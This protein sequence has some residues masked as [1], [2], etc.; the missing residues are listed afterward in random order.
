[1]ALLSLKFAHLSLMNR[2]MAQQPQTQYSP[3]LVLNRLPAN[4]PGELRAWSGADQILCDYVQNNFANSL[5]LSIWNDDFGAIS[6]ILN[7]YAQDWYS[8]SWLAHQA[9]ELNRSQNSLPKQKAN[10]LTC[11]VTPA[12]VWLIKI[13]KS[14]ALFEYQLSQ[15]AAVAKPDQPIIFTGMV[16]FIAKGFFKLIESYL[17]DL[18]TSLAQK[19]AR[20]IFTQKQQPNREA[21][22][23]LK[24]RATPYPWQLCD[25]AGV[26]CLGKLDIGSRFMLEHLPEGNYQQIVDLG[27]GNGLLTL[28]AL[29]RWPNA[30]YH[31]CDESLMA[32]ASAQTNIAQNY[33][34]QASQVNFRA[35]HCLSQHPDNSADL[36]LCNPPFHQQQ[37]I[38]TYIAETMFADA[39]RSLRGNG[40]LC[41]VAN[42]H[43]PYRN[44]LKKRFNDVKVL[45][46]NS[47]FVIL[48][49][50]K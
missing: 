41:V 46:S 13:P 5:K 30:T 22:Y 37:V 12:D 50:K 23:P 4:H 6:C 27:C 2:P 26:F 7:D 40:E 49:A 34:K 11:E 33:P 8:D 36:V 18:S 32:V 9:L 48:I 19:K 3:T 42:R 14:L 45:A 39:F 25:H 43:L 31:C 16:K 15:I 17:G 20:L 35:D 44:L 29:N 47:K 28:G 38:S 21:P 24:W 10:A 1:M